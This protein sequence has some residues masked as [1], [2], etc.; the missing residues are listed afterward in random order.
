[1]MKAG[2]TSCALG[3]NAVGTLDAQHLCTTPNENGSFSS[4][5]IYFPEL[6][7]DTSQ[8]PSIVLVGGWGCGEKVLAAWA[9]FLASHGIVAMTIGTPAHTVER[10]TT[11]PQPS[12][13]RCEHGLAVGA[14]T[15]C[16]A[17]I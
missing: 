15:C 11:R 2:P 16:L 9:P 5:T 3:P 1:M 12:T 14:H 7:S 13:A 6:E 4:A 17:I 10:C 8:L